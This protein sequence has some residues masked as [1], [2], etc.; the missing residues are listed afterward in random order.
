MRKPSV[1]IQTF[2]LSCEIMSHLL[3]TYERE[4]E[5]TLHKS[6]QHSREQK[7]YRR[8]FSYS[9]EFYLHIYVQFVVDQHTI[10]IF[11]CCQS[12]ICLLFTADYEMMG[13]LADLLFDFNRLRV[14]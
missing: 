8:G 13:F 9:V 1:E 10:K 11:F 3:L 12:R 14:S 5:I 4:N 2:Y 6:N 7:A